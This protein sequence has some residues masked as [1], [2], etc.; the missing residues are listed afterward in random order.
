MRNM[1]VK[2]RVLVLRKLT[3]EVEERLAKTYEAVFS[4]DDKPMVPEAIAQALYDYEA[5]VPTVSDRIT[6]VMLKGAGV[7]TRMIANVGV[8]CSN[9]DVAAARDAG[10]A[11][12]NT[13]DVLTDATADTALLLILSVTR[14]AFAAEKMLREGRWGGFSIVGGLGASIQDKVL[15]I[16]GMGRIGQAVARRAALGF[17]MK[18]VYYNRSPVSGLG[19][20]AQ[21]LDSIDAVMAVADVVSVHVPGGGG[22]PLVTAAHIARMKP[23][24]YLV[25]TARGDSL[26][27]TALIAALAGKRIAG[28]GFDVFAKEPEVPE[29]LRKMENV[30]LLPH[31]GSATEEVRTAMGHMAV[32]NLDAYFEGRALPSRVV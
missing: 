9:I 23:S 32:D 1:L 28:A 29:T 15:G 24:A 7:R 25:N 4:L 13:P 12:S 10:I 19:F 2:P 11:V 22:T 14:R 6:A 17:G 27:Q 30:T 20:E 8:G 26:D 3:A 16:I 18:I 31:I 21:G 5:L